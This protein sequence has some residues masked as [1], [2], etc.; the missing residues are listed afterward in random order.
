[1][2]TQ[3]VLVIGAGMV[4]GPAIEYLSQF[5]PVH[6]VDIKLENINKVLDTIRQQR[7]NTDG[8]THSVSPE[9]P[10]LERLIEEHDVVIGLTQASLLPGFAEQCVRHGTH[11]V[12]SSYAGPEMRALDKAARAKGVTLLNECGLDPGLDH[13]SA[14]ALIESI[15]RE[16]ARICS[17]ES[18]CG[19]VPAQADAN[20]IGY[21]VSW[22]PVQVLRSAKASAKFLRGGT[23]V[24]IENGALYNNTFPVTVF[25]TPYEGF[26]NRD[27]FP[28]LRA[29]G[30]EREL[31]KGTF[32]RGTL[33]HP[34]WGSFMQS[35]QL[36][37]YLDETPLNGERNYRD[38]LS[39]LLHRNVNGDAR[40]H[41]AARLGMP[42]HDRVLSQL[43][44]LGL[45]SN[46][47]LP[48][49]CSTPL[50]LLAET[51]RQ[52]LAYK[53]GE[54]DAVVMQHCADVRYPEG[55]MI[56]LTSSMRYEGNGWSAMATTVGLPVALAAEQL[57]TGSVVE[58]GVLLPTSP[59]IYR[60]VL[61]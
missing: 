56:R 55:N 20:P 15:H 50:S 37:G 57:L 7:G 54:Q 34:G 26:Y 21:K 25:N 6:I 33:R 4:A 59:E 2:V 46:Q 31:E 36:L 51:M 22:S 11:F 13:M 52:R 9:P 49:N 27:A 60:P 29:Y 19:G 30:L 24:L 8:I 17:F 43:D 47:Q 48:K 38:V 39:T 16:R 35:L 32:I 42:E 3:R 18:H 5:Y 45:F 12:T 28:Y 44:Y 53:E 61:E 14:A 10:E 58:R 23:P 1:M 41:V 40:A